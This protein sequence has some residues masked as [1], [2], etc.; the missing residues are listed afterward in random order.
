MAKPIKMLDLH[1]PM[2]QFL[3]KDDI[4]HLRKLSGSQ[5]T[6]CNYLH[7]CFDLTTGNCLE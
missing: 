1:Y 2:I 5:D 3:I 7:H 6:Q 4:T